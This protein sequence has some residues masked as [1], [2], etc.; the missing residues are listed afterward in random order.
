MF[1]EKELRSWGR[2]YALWAKAMA[3]DQGQG[4][5]LGSRKEIYIQA[6]RAGQRATER[7]VYV[8]ELLMSCLNHICANDS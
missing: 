7:R 1:T 2:G 8:W 6:L 5:R 4:F 3:W